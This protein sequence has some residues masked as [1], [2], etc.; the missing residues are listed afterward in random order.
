MTLDPWASPN[1]CQV[2]LVN[3]ARDNGTPPLRSLAS[4]GRRRSKVSRER[5]QSFEQQPHVLAA[6]AKTATTIA[7]TPAA[8]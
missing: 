3:A 6:K 7:R 5:A 4:T 8:R 1:V 2:T